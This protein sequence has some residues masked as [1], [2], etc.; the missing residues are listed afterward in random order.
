MK[1]KDIRTAASAANM[2]LWQVADKLGIN[3]S[4][5]SRKLRYEL[6][7]TEKQKIL[8]IINAHTPD[9]PPDDKGGG[10]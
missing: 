10:L 7:D 8:A 3:D 2:P 9:D 5:L 4:Q 6:S 1:N